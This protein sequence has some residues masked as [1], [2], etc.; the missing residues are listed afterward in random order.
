TVVSTG[1]TVQRAQRGD[2]ALGVLGLLPGTWSN[3]PDFQ[4]HGWN[5]IALPLAQPG[6]VIVPPQTSDYRLLLNQ[7]NEILKFENVDK[8]VPNRGAAQTALFDA[9][10]HVAALQY[11]QHVEQIAAEDFP[12]TPDTPDT[13]NGPKAIHHEPGLFLNLLSQVDGGPEIARL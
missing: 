1:R 6:K 10:Q 3:K 9:D 4:G 2:E 7:T 12:A 8:G 11:I 13:P 5:M